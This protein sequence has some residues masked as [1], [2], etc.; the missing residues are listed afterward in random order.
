MRKKIPTVLIATVFAI[1]TPV[2]GIGETSA[3]TIDVTD[4]VNKDFVRSLS[5][6][7]VYQ[8][9]AKTYNKISNNNKVTLSFIDESKAALNLQLNNGKTILLKDITYT[10]K[11]SKDSNSDLTVIR[12][13]ASLNSDEFV[14]FN[15]IYDKVENANGNIT[16]TKKSTTLQPNG[17]KSVTY[18]DTK[19]RF[20]K[21]TD[22]APDIIQSLNKNSNQSLNQNSQITPYASIDYP[23]TI[24]YK[25]GNKFYVGYLMNYNYIQGNGGQN[26]FQIKLSPLGSLYTYKH[27]TG[28]TGRLRE[29]LSYISKFL[30]RHERI[31]GVGMQTYPNISNS[32]NKSFDVDLTFAFPAGIGFGYT[33]KVPISGSNSEEH[34]NKARWDM[35]DVLLDMSSNGSPVNA[36]YMYGYIA[37]TGSGTTTFSSGASATLSAIYNFPN[38]PAV[39]VDISED[40]PLPNKTIN[41]KP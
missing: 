24:N 4:Q 25:Y 40:I 35:Y 17:S 9:D 30:F 15:M 11:T 21:G 41:V 37:G 10:K 22:I 1:S 23:Q 14:S 13:K 26:P 19:Y 29:D 6:E 28:E 39:I 12:G 16:I 32:P 33:V 3:Q 20:Y 8:F 31:S 34:G 18:N 36:F 7:N 38:Q 27:Y 5:F 2:G